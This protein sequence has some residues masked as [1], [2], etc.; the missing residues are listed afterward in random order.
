[1]NYEKQTD[2]IVL[3]EFAFTHGYQSCAIMSLVHARSNRGGNM[4]LGFFEYYVIGIN[5]IGFL[6]FLV[7]QLLYSFTD[8]G[9]IDAAVTVASFL[10]GSAGII[11]AM[12]LFSREAVKENMMSRI[13]VACIFII[14]VIIFLIVEGYISNEITLDFLGYFERHKPLLIYLVVINFITLIAFALDK[15]AAIEDKTRIRIVTLL[16]LA[17]VGGSIGGL[18]AMYV[19][20]HKTRI[21]YFTVG[22]PLIIIMQVIVI[23]YL[24][25]MRPVA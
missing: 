13:F 11:L 21:D 16:G 22:I 14:Q 2:I 1:M 10:G 3:Y 23:F 5:I 15:I 6:L 18:I 19:F 4:E 24:M 9:Q 7:N 8:E 12:L 25:N 20:R 17:F